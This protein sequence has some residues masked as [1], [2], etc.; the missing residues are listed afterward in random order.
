MALA[1]ASKQQALY[2]LPL[3][4]A[5]GWAM[6]RLTLRGGLSSLAA[7]AAGIAATA[8]W[9]GL[10]AQPTSLWALAL[11]NNNPARLIRSDEVAP[12]LIVWLNYGR[13]LV[14]TEPAGH[15][16]RVRWCDG[17]G[18]GERAV[19]VHVGTER[20]VTEASEHLG[21]VF[22]VLVE[23]PPFVYD[24]NAR[25]LSLNRVIPGNET[26]AG[27]TVGGVIDCLRFDFGGGELGEE[28]QTAE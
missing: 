16:E 19:A 4:W 11:A 3:A 6:N 7:L 25:P 1:F 12:R 28:Q 13:T 27:D 9:D 18:R 2:L 14:G 20:D 23:A 21:A 8:G 17:D 26:L 24:H 5:L 10:R 15:R 22:R